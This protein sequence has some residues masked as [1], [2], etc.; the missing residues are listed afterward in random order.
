[1]TR[2]GM[3][4]ILRKEI[5]RVIFIKIDETPR[6]MECTLI[7][8]FLPPQTER[9]CGIQVGSDEVITVWDLEKDAWRA[10]RIDRVV[11]FDVVS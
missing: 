5:V 4:E 7:S 9:G 3:I 6:A 8:D 2:S 1:M 10:F 11:T